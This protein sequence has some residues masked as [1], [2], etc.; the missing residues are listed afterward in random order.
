MTERSRGEIG[1]M[2]RDDLERMMN[3]A[4]KVH[5][6]NEQERGLSHKLAGIIADAILTSVRDT[7]AVVKIANVLG[8]AQLPADSPASAMYGL[9]FEATGAAVRDPIELQ[10]LLRKIAVGAKGLEGGP[11]ALN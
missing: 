5:Q 11:L 6:K 7:D 4:F 9:I 8:S 2:L 1:I 3:A 10:T